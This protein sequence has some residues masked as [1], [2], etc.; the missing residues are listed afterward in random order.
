MLTIETQAGTLKPSSNVSA[1]ALTVRGPCVTKVAARWTQ[2]GWQ[3][4]VAVGERGTVGAGVTVGVG[5]VGGMAV[6]VG[7]AV[8]TG[9]AAGVAEGVKDGT[10]AA[11]AAASMTISRA[12]AA[13]R[14]RYI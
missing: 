10:G 1:T 7:V 14:L 2:F 11:H 5:V 3:D 12:I 8:G 4:V 9:V 13:A 6:G